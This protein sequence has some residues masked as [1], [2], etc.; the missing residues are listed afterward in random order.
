M[1]FI[2][3]SKRYIQ[4]LAAIRSHEVYKFKKFKRENKM[5]KM[6]KKWKYFEL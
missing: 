1:R 2:K 3:L 6:S 5:I 4:D